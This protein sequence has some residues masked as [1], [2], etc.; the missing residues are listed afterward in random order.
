MLETFGTF[1]FGRKDCGI[2]AGFVD[3]K[4]KLLSTERIDEV[5]F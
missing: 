1:Q 2:E 5:P 3:E 4:S